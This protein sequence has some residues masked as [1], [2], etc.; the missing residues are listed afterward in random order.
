MLSLTRVSEAKALPI[1]ALTIPS[2]RRYLDYFSRSLSG[3]RPRSHGVMLQRVIMHTVPCFEQR[4]PAGTEGR[5]EGGCRPYLELLQ[6]GRHLIWSSVS[7]TSSSSTAASASASASESTDHRTAMRRVEAYWTDDACAKF[8]ADESV[9]AIVVT[10]S[11]R[12]FAAG[13]DISEMATM[14]FPEVYVKNMFEAWTGMGRVVKPTIAAVNGFALGGGCELAM[15]CDVIIAGDG[16]KFGQPEITL[17]TIPGCGGTQRLVRAVGK[18]KAMEMCLTGVM[19]DAEEALDCGLV[20]RVYPANDLEAEAEK[21]AAKMAS[22]SKPAAAMT[23]E[24]INAAFEVSLAEGVRWER[25]LFHSTFATKD[26]KAGMAAFLAKE[27]AT[28]S[29][30]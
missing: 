19:I 2:Q 29:D 23:K 27:K 28:W 1:G 5:I 16:A 24:A 12:A 6:A 22:F 3:R 15:M 4:S 17:G 7:S 20:A 8:D 18:S 30:E 25:R 26:Q 14:Q 10:G 9:G 21:M 11:Q 13:A